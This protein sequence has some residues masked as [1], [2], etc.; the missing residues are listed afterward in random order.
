[1]SAWGW[2]NL[3]S[4]LKAGY[5]ADSSARE[6]LTAL[7]RRVKRI[8]EKSSPVFAVFGRLFLVRRPLQ[9]VKN[10]RLGGDNAILHGSRPAM[11]MTQALASILSICITISTGL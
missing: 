7:L 9:R 11:P 8:V 3:P 4:W 5:A 2:A 1:M 6:Y 10:E